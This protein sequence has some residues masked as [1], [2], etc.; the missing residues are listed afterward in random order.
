[1][2]TRNRRSGRKLTQI[3]AGALQLAILA[4]AATAALP[5]R[6]SEPGAERPV[7]QRVAPSYPEMAK[8]LKISGEVRVS[9]TV[10][11]SGKVSAAKSISGS[12]LLAGAAEDAVRKWKFEPA[13]SESTVEV[14]VNFALAQ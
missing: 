13:D 10:A 2:N 6:A 4:M 12:G 1:M 5:A 7:K 8:R 11:P 3:I 14:K 9:A